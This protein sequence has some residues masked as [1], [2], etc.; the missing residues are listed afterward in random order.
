M[1]RCMNRKAHWEA[2]YR[3]NPADEVSWFQ[4]RPETSL[5]LI[6]A[7]GISPQDGVIDVGAGASL[8]V[9]CLLAEGYTNLAV[10]DISSAALAVARQRVGA[11]A[12]AVRWLEADVTELRP[13]E[14]FALW[15]DRAVFHFLT[16][17]DERAR[18]VEALKTAL[19]PDGHVIIAT[20]ALDGPAK[21]SGLEVA[22]YDATGLGA[23]LGVEFHFREQVDEAHRTPWQTEQHFSYFRFERRS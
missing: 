17:R 4:P 6:A 20:F 14:R 18:Y 1:L 5:R 12:A 7:S 10:L 16:T 11:R 9:D 3:D 2:V 8:L 23:E 15:H 22:R 19:R 21:C 13:A